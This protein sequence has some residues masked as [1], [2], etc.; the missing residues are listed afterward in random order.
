M[1]P[2]LEI[3]EYIVHP[4]YDVFHSCGHSDTNWDCC[5]EPYT[6]PE[7][8]TVRLRIANPV[9]T[10]DTFPSMTLAETWLLGELSVKYSL[11]A[12]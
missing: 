12:V 6:V 11:S 4:A 5:C 9:A 3:V 2:F 10:D 8:V 7:S 1:K